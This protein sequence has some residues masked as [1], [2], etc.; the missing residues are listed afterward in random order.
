MTP[1]EQF[2][3]CFKLFGDYRAENTAHVQD[4]PFSVFKLEHICPWSQLVSF[5]IDDSE[6]PEVFWD[7]TDGCDAAKAQV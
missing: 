7:G 4:L 6:I 1:V 5:Q 2:W 3:S